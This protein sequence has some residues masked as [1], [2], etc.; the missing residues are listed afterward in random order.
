MRCFLFGLARVIAAAAMASSF[1]I[2][3]SEAGQQP[4][5]GAT[6]RPAAQAPAATCGSARTSA[7]IANL[8]DVSSTSPPSVAHGGVI[9]VSWEL[10][11][12]QAAPGRSYL[13]GAMP[14]SVRFEGLYQLDQDGILASGPGFLALPAG[15]RA[16]YGITI[17]ADRT[18]IVVPIDDADVPR[19][20]ALR[21]R[22]Y[23]A[24]PLS[25]EWTV[26][27]VDAACAPQDPGRL[28]KTPIKTLGPYQIAPGS[29]AIVVQDF[30]TPDPILELAQPN[31][32][33]RLS[34][35]EIS[36]DGR[37]R[38]EIFP[39]RYRVFDRVS[40]AKL[41]DR[42]GVKARFSPQG[43]FVVASVGD[44]NQ[45]YPTN[46][47]IIDL[48]A[49]KVVGRAGGPIVGWSN[50]DALLLDGGRAYQS[51][52]L[53]APLIDPVQ[54]S[55]G[56]TANWLTYFPGCG[57][58]DAWTSSNIHID[59]NRL[60]VLRADASSERA[61]GIANFSSGRKY[62][63]T[64]FGDEEAVPLEG[65][66]QRVYG[67]PDE[68]VATGW[69][70]DAS[71]G[72]THVGRG[73]DGYADE[74]ASLQPSDTARKGQLDFVVPRRLALANGQVLIAQ[75]LKP[76]GTAR[77]SEPQSTATS[78]RRSI[79]DQE[80][81]GTE[82]ATFGLKLAATEPVAEIEI[83]LA[84]IA[85][86]HDPLVR[87]WPTALKDEIVAAN[88]ELKAWFKD[89]EFPD[90][91]V[92]AWRLSVDGTRYLL[93]QHGSPAMTVNGAH[94]LSFDLVALDGGKPGT[95]LKLADISGLFSQFV[96]RE[97]TVA[98][99]AQLSRG[100]LVVAVPGSGRAVV[101]N[102]ANG[103]A[104]KAFDLVEP[105][106]TCGFY[107]VEKRDLIV[108]GN[109]DGQLFVFE[110]DK[111]SAPLLSGRVVDNELVLY[112]AQGFYA[113]TYEGAHFVHV[114]FPGLPG[115][116]SFEQ[117]AK[118]LA[119]PDVIS[120]LVSGQPVNVPAPLIT[121]PPDVEGRVQGDHT[122]FA[123]SAKAQSPTGIATVEL[124]EDGRLVD[125]Q[126]IRGTTVNAVFRRTV[127]PHVRGFSLVAIDANGFSSRPLPLPAPAADPAQTTNVLH[128]IAVGVDVYDQIGPL[129]GARFDA[130]RLVAEVQ[131]HAR[132]YH[133][134][135][136]TIRVDRDA[137]PSAVMTD[138]RSAITAAGPDD[139][140][141]FFFAGHG[142]RTDDGRYFMAVPTTDPA[143]LAETAIDWQ[144]AAQLLGSTKGRVIAILDAC[145]SGQTAVAPVPNDGA[146]A[147][148]ASVAQAPMVVLAASK[149]R[150]LSEES[151]DGAGGV[152]TQTLAKLLGKD[153]R[154]TDANGDGVLQTSEIYRNLRQ[155][156]DAATGARQTPWL[157]RRNI[158]GDAPLF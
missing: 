120:G 119:R 128:V 57:T 109:C 49:G 150:Q 149:G 87:N 40:G 77:S 157:V 48:V 154:A 130:E 15:S 92:A 59:W 42:S 141:L 5:A 156:V 114:T 103:G 131:A 37:Y 10:P 78:N 97:H 142:G 125:R 136:T 35:V 25:I 30:V 113:S 144:Q 137:T 93:V 85:G 33:Q 111:Q 24:G 36:Q 14:N 54:G 155:S 18:R 6:A 11:A 79:L 151:P 132:Y 95:V 107:E 7:S 127:Q 152:F 13:V 43:R 145:H 126:N 21:I 73:Y 96:G 74:E 80:S 8:I 117:F 110:P 124:Y 134:V 64:S 26:V 121:P 105:T 76:A 29:P 94:D 55:D 44:A 102:L 16:P 41:I 122:A 20:N 1:P 146:V 27:T 106:V 31:G 118:V 2:S 139:T 158:V 51:V 138:I 4:P 88:A 84:D 72:L 108:Q 143:R 89:E 140:I 65:E 32:A 82:L 19:A 61:M 63:T 70:S 75:D 115:V 66:L 112:T 99:V 47:E 17:A 123:I 81:V 133:A 52:T 69:T 34:E 39:R 148:L 104:T 71:L 68:P 23:V 101:V 12:P 90:I 60:T 45:T 22:P 83:P 3:P 153:R 129:D 116:H 38:L 147:S 91:V 58:C 67:R 86:G 28:A 56:S 62:E 98:R 100:R 46:F 53:V 9:E 50:G 135:K